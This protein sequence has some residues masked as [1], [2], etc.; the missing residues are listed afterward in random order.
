MREKRKG[1]ERK[2]HWLN[3]SG[4][5]ARGTNNQLQGKRKGTGQVHSS[6]EKKGDSGK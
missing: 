6:P 4:N 1:K 3:C 5:H 2:C